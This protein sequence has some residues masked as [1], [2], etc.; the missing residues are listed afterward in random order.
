MKT[1]HPNDVPKYHAT[2]EQLEQMF[3]RTVQQA[4]DER[5]A[6]QSAAEW[7]LQVEKLLATLVGK[8]SALEGRIAELETGK[9]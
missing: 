2:P 6:K 7:P 1:N 8:V 3:A 5:A 4:L 9:G